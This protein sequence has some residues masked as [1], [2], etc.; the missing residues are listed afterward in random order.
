[1]KQFF[2]RV[3]G[4]LG[5]G[6]TWGIGGF[7]IGMGIELVHN[8]WPNPLG[9]AVDIWPMTL[10]LPGLLGGV[11]FSTVLGIAGR[12]HRFGELSLPKFAAWGAIGGLIVSLFPA[13]M[14]ALGLASPNVPIWEITAWLAGP[15]VLG[16]AVAASGS[17]ALARLSEDRALLAVSEDLADLGLTEEESREFLGEA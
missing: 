17:L 3:R 6:L 2:R 10:A 8:I 7:A 13:A 5:L 4:A 14:V 11:A 1:M 12:R 16:G 15:C 9:G